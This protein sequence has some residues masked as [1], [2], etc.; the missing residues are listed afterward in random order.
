MAS[1]RSAEEEAPRSA[2]R[3]S[4]RATGW[5]GRVLEPGEAVSRL[6]SAGLAGAWIEVVSQYSSLGVVPRD[7]LERVGKVLDVDPIAFGIVVEMNR[8]DHVGLQRAMT[9]L[10]LNYIILEVRSAEVVW[11]AVCSTIAKR[12]NSPPSSDVLL[13][14]TLTRVAELMPRL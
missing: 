11:E 13:R 8:Q 10:S 2:P 9:R 4:V 6:D 12:V 14:A 5:S 1:S 7:V 3:P